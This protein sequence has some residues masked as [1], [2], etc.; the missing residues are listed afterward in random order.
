MSLEI[1]AYQSIPIEKVQNFNQ[2]W[3]K[4]RLQATPQEIC[5]NGIAT[6]KMV[7]LQRQ[8]NSLNGVAATAPLLRNKSW[9]ASV[10]ENLHR[11]PC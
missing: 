11:T 4:A 2:V 3:F 6:P 9:R 1:K 5:R 7:L 10:I 8:S